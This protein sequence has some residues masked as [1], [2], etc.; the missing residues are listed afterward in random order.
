MS[1]PGIGFHRNANKAKHVKND[2]GKPKFSLVPPRALR[3]IA[4]ALTYGEEKYP[5]NDYRKVENGYMR[6]NDAARRHQNAYDC[7]EIVD[8]ESEQLHL[9]L[10]IVNKMFMLEI[11]ILSLEA[12][13][14]DE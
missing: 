12:Q 2:E 13:Q 8:E 6:Y 3:A 14:Q 10:E 5:G 11:L 9:A 1:K 4:E 7:D